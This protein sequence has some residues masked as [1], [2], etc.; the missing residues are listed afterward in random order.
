MSED[1]DPASGVKKYDFH[2]FALEREKFLL[3][4]ITKLPKKL[5]TE[6]DIIW[7]LILILN[8]DLIIIS[9]I[10]LNEIKIFNFKLFLGINFDSK[11]G[12]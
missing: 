8:L 4:E 11:F 2:I 9:K 10:I 3:K 12:L 1:D 6:V 7:G 5:T